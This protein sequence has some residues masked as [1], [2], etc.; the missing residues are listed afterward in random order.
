[1]AKK[2]LN[3]DIL[4]GASISDNNKSSS[5]S[6]KAAK[7][8]KK[9]KKA[10][11]KKEKLDKQIKE[12]KNQISEETNEKAKTSLQKKLDRA[13]NSLDALNGKKSA[14]SSNNMKIVK[15]VVAVVI[16]VALLV[17][18]VATGAVRKGFIHSTLQWTTGITAATVKTDDGDKIKIPVSTY[19]Y[20]FAMI[21]NNLKNTQSQYEQYGIDLSQ[22]NLDVDFDKPFSKQTT[23]DDNGKVVTWLEYV[24]ERVLNSIKSTYM[25]YN[26]A[27]K[28]NNGEEPEITEDQRKEINDSVA[29]Y[30]ETANQYGY[31]VSGYLV[32]AMGK[33]VTEKVY[34]R[35][36]RR[37]YIAENYS[38]SLSDEVT[39]KEYTDEDYDNYKNEHLAELQAVSFR[40]FEADNED[41]AKEFKAELKSDGSNFTQLCEKYATDD[42]DKSLYSQDENST[43]YSATRESLESAGGYAIAT[44]KDTDADEK[45]YPGLDWLF[46][47]DRKEGDIYQYST[48]VVY[49]LKPAAL[50]EEDTVNVRH[51]LISPTDSS[52]TSS[53]SSA[54]DEQW[55]EA[56]STA[57][58]VL[59]EYNSGDKTE[60][61]F[62]AL[63]SDYSTDT[64]SSSNGG[65]YENIVPGQM[66]LPFESWVLNPQ[67]KAGDVGIVQT[68]YGYHIIYFVGRTETP[69]W[70]AVA[71][72]ALS[73]EDSK[74][75]SEKLDESYTISMDW[76]GKF[77]VEKDTDIDS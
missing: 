29:Q 57:E 45:E 19:N 3:E 6:K 73:S 77:Y 20:Y 30:K 21:Y 28:A 68:T 62:A 8:A 13:K 33:G 48:S 43:K 14:V 34:R 41:S 61:S 24:N 52:S 75:E 76:F 54:T 4:S 51:I 25:Y 26:E 74:T 5:D 71:Q 16:V 50:A 23:T 58:K 49:V 65:L 9:S 39:S 63:V 11:E 32:Q 64:G 72:N 31:T 69:I 56:L 60:D 67:R 2:D 42:L 44:A 55:A 35:E 59:D 7:L 46:S 10:A 40:I 66:V 18:Y 47:S 37:A 12:L 38:S 36:A 27:V 1:M 22:N 17:T 70:K 53:S 15:S